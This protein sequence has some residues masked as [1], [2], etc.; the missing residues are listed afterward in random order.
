MS[1]NVR[2]QRGFTLLE[3]MVATAIFVVIMVAAL[4]LYS[5]SNKVFKHGV[6]SADTQQSTRIAFDKLV[7]DV[8]M[9]GFDYDRDGVPAVSN[10][11]VWTANRNYNF[12]DTV[13]PTVA[14]GRVYRA[15][16]AGQA[17]GTEPIWPTVPG[18]TVID[19]GVT[20]VT[21]GTAVFQQP[22]EQI[23]FAGTS[24]ITIRGNFDYTERTNDAAYAF[25][26]EPDY[27]P[28]AKQFPIVTTENREIVTYALRANDCTGYT[29]CNQDSVVFFADTAKPR[30][31]YPGGAAENQITIPNV[32]FSNAHPPY[33]LFRFII[34][35]NGQPT[36]GVPVANNIRSL[37]FNYYTDTHGTTLL[38]QANGTAIANGAIGGLG[39]Y[40]PANLGTTANYTDRQQRGLIQS[41]AVRLVGMNENPDA[42]YSNATETI[43]AMKNYRQYEL[44]SLVLPRNVGMSGIA[45]VEN[46]PPG[47]P[48]VTGVCVGYCRTPVVYWNPPASGFVDTYEVHWDTNSIGGYAA[49]VNTG[50]PVLSFPVVG[51]TS[52]TTYYFKVVAINQSGRAM[53]DNFVAGT[54]TNMTQPKAPT[55][56]TATN[57][58]TPALN[59]QIRLTW[60]EVTQNQNP[61][62]QLSCNPSGSGDPD[63]SSIRYENT[64]Y[65]L[66]RSTNQFFDPN[67]PGAATVVLDNTSLSQPT[68]AGSGT[69]TW[70][71]TQATANG[72]N[73][74]AAC[75][76]YYYK[77]QTF[78]TCSLVATENTPAAFSTG[79]STIFPAAAAAGILGRSTSTSTPAAPIGPAIGSSSAAGTNWTVN[80]TWPPV[81]RD[82]SNNPLSIYS[83]DLYRAQKLATDI[84]P[85]V[86]PG[87]PIATINGATTYSD[88]V[89]Q[90]NGAGVSY[91]YKYWVKAKNCSATSAASGGVTFPNTC[92]FTFSVSPASSSNSPAMVNALDSVVVTQTSAT[93]FTSAVFTLY[94]GANVID[95]QTVTP[96]G[97]P[98]TA[99]YAIPDT[100]DPAVS[101]Y[102]LQIDVTNGPCT[103]TAYAYLEQEFAPGCEVTRAT[104]P[105]AFTSVTSGSNRRTTI[106]FQF[107]NTST[108]NLTITGIKIDFAKPSGMIKSNPEFGLYSSTAN[109]VH[110]VFTGASS[111]DLEVTAPRLAPGTG[112]ATV[113]GAPVIP[114]GGNYTIAPVFEY[115]KQ[116]NGGNAITANPITKI[117]IKY[118]DPAFPTEPRFCNIFNSASAANANPTACE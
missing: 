24:A 74:P 48:T 99:A 28:G 69:L 43:A 11:T 13:V 101:F 72:G 36:A 98:R 53:S 63:A 75:V 41:V 12:G 19:N 91:Y 20:W 94:D 17:G 1:K 21:Q 31:A 67:T 29:N 10:T 117:C 60:S 79:Q 90:D 114:A 15:K 105:G 92:P 26:R 70:T 106:P 8:R 108:N 77:I 56:L 22:D 52:G 87:T 66:W 7:M 81:T 30:A 33:T 27:E 50:G 6:E 39:Q 45:E 2:N 38:T 112:Q 111:V 14:N 116:D 62:D 97:S 32:D 57:S 61:L 109:K 83:Y 82:T 76:D 86:I 35:E 47:K 40:D 113:S 85:F 89:P 103:T 16:T 58:T 9:A 64:Y 5:R 104:S 115:D 49:F 37:T 118:I 110:I 42:D 51:L 55:T 18:V 93:N 71:D 65:R 84:T 80:L 3:V 23:E 46:T 68:G 4:V 100:L 88:L 25:G 59:N 96:S 44:Q 54:P 95:T 73:G 102:T 34:G 107:T 78:D